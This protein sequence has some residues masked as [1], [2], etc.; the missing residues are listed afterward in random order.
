MNRLKWLVGV[1]CLV[2][3][4][5]VAAPIGFATAVF[6]E[7]PGGFGRVE[8][9]NSA[10]V[11]NQ[12]FTF[13]DVG[14]GAIGG[15]AAASYLSL[16]TSAF[17]TATSSN[18]CCSNG[19]T[20][21]SDAVAQEILTP[22]AVGL[23]GGTGFMSIGFKIT[24]KNLATV[25]NPGPLATSA[26]A[27]VNVEAGPDFA[28][29]NPVG[30]TGP[31]PSSV[32]GHN[33]FDALEYNGSAFTV[34]VPISFDTPI[35]TWIQLLSVAEGSVTDGGL[36]SATS[37]FHTTLVLDSIR[38][39]DS[40]LQPVANPSLV[41]ASGTVYPLVGGAAAGVPEPDSMLLVVGGL[42][43]LGAARCLR[44]RRGSPGPLSSVRSKISA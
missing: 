34:N 2:C 11:P 35:V 14:S 4:Q 36:Y 30:T 24:G 12:S 19:A 22:G 40:A 26:R 17:S 38:L 8:G 1:A 39:L 10:I 27:V 7:F 37:S 28:N 41:S 44:V 23:S 15:N 6:Y 18:P 33:V 43:A 3:G 9:T 20:V 31:F 25:I 5:A 29:G 21:R 13:P 32:Y 16:G 42:L